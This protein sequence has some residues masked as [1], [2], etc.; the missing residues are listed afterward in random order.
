MMLEHSMDRTLVHY[1][2][3]CTHSC[4][5]DGYQ[6]SGLHWTPWYCDLVMLP[7]TMLLCIGLDFGKYCRL[8]SK[9]FQVCTNKNKPV[10]RW[11]SS[12]GTVLGF[13]SPK[14]NKELSEDILTVRCSGRMITYLVMPQSCFQSSR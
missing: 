13:L 4:T 5:P 2:A 7:A 11:D 10:S 8:H 9:V 3:L 14:N 6:R 1:R 12:V